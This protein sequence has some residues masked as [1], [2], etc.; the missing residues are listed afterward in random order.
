MGFNSVFKG[1]N[2]QANESHVRPVISRAAI[3]LFVR[4]KLGLC[5]LV[6]KSR[7]WRQRHRGSIPSKGKRLVFSKPELWDSPRFHSRGT[8]GKATWVWRWPLPSI[9]EII[10]KLWSYTATPPY[11]FVALYFI[12]Q[13]AALRY[14]S[15][16]LRRMFDGNSGKFRR[17][18][19]AAVC[20]CYIDATL[21]LQMRLHLLWFPNRV[22]FFECS[23]RFAVSCRLI[24]ISFTGF[25]L[26]LEICMP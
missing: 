1:L 16:M 26:H 3:N 21:R 23:L 10:K 24:A 17:C 15:P 5:W 25:D 20:L 6:T 13:R 8:G 2:K 14:L 19:Y 22:I 18:R 11:I 7:A 12:T 4:V 9:V